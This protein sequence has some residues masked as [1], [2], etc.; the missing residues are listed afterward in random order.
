[1]V[2]DNSNGKAFHSNFVDSKTA[3]WYYYTETAA[4]IQANGVTKLCTGDKMQISEK[5]ACFWGMI[6]LI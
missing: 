3:F 2:L 5:N 6:V 1:M 4:Q